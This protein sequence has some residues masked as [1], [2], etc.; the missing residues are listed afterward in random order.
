MA[1]NI[2]KTRAEENRRERLPLDKS[3]SP[4][5]WSESLGFK[6]PASGYFNNVNCAQTQMPPG[7][8]RRLKRW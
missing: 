1:L 5:Y 3:Y 2:A 6:I 7:R 4:Y 8:S